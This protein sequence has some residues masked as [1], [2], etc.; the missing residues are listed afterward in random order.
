MC[1]HIQLNIIHTNEDKSTQQPKLSA[2]FEYVLHSYLKEKQ[3][4][5][6]INLYNITN[7]S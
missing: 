5:F 2:P 4:F 3:V 7:I 1:N 6:K